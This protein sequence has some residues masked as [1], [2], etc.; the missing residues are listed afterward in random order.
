VSSS[1]R[2]LLIL[3]MHRSGTSALAEVLARLGV[4]LGSDPMPTNEFNP[5]GFGE[6]REIVRIHDA[7]LAEVGSGWQDLAP[8]EIPCESSAA[9]RAQS[10]LRELLRR[11]TAGAALFGVKD[12]RL[13]RLL[14]LWRPVLASERLEAAALIVLRHPAEVAGSL[15]HRDAFARSRSQALWLDHV[16]S[17]DHATR[18]LPRAF[19]WF[20]SL[21]RD[22]HEALTGIAERLGIVWPRDPEAARDEIDA[23]LSPD[24]RHHAREWREPPHPWVEA[25]HGLLRDHW[26][27]DDEVLRGG[28]DRI[29]RDFHV[30]RA[31]F[32]TDL[33][34]L[35]RSERRTQELERRNRKL[36]RKLASPRAWA[37][38]FLRS[39]LATRRSRDGQY[40]GPV[41]TREEAEAAHRR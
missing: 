26:E 40:P 41:T 17:A 27:S 3:G 5:R 18:E 9:R 1:G 35:G 2:L 10:A 14:P 38:A 8:P 20:D 16:L 12:P 25:A 28:L 19:V 6:H 36:E 15:A 23:F 24:L 13:C 30:A 39:R 11:D 33:R 34:A 29:R 4:S 31:L 32:E 22:W 37:R 21:L 7:L